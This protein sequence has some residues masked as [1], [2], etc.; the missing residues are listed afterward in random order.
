MI[1]AQKHTDDKIRK[2][3]RDIYKCEYDLVYNKTDSFYHLA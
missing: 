3:F 1:Q 2:T